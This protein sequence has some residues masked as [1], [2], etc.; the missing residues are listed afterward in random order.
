MQHKIDTLELLQQIKL[1]LGKEEHKQFMQNCKNFRLENGQKLL[2]VY[3]EILRQLVD[4]KKNGP[5][6]ENLDELMSELE[7]FYI[8]YYH[9]TKD[10]YES[11]QEENLTML[12]RFTEVIINSIVSSPEELI[13]LLEVVKND[14][15]WLEEI[16][17]RSYQHPIGFK[18]FILLKHYSD[19][20]DEQT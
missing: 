9:N 14:V 3:D 19:E 18:K 16:A 1:A 20:I 2:L 12:F 11:V 6:H 4:I 15:E 7:T 17:Q 8:S 10:M 13:Q 5:N